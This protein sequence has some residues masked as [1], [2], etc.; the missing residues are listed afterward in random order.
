MKRNFKRV[1][2]IGYSPLAAVI[3]GLF[4]LFGL[5]VYADMYFES[6]TTQNAPDQVELEEIEM[7]YVTADK[8]KIVLSDGEIVIFR[9]DKGLM[10]DIDSASK[11]YTETTFKEIKESAQQSMK[12][13]EEALAKLPPK[14]RKEMEQFLPQFGASKKIEVKIEKT[15]EKR[16]VSNYK[17]ELIIAATDTTRS[18]MWVTEQIK[19]DKD[20]KKFFEA[21]SS[22][23]SDIPSFQEMASM[24]QALTKIEGVPMETETIVTMGT[25]SHT[26][27]SIV[28][29]VEQRKIN[30]SE[31]E[32]PAGLKKV[33]VE[34]VP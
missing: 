5:N 27:I 9:L 7:T 30:D 26:S 29:K 19:Y 14:E 6:K 3:A 18:E 31:F 34:E 21:M 22:I 16:D 25:E 15:G 10:W 2:A 13:I 11:T 1:L 24:Y 4:C 8:M 33:V 28:S 12:D 23:F 32:L 20:A 17:C